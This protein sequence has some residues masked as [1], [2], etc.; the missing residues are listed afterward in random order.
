MTLKSTRKVL[1]HSL[2]RSIVGSHRSLIRLL[3][4]ARFARALRY[5]PLRSAMLAHSLTPELMRKRIWSTERM[6]RFHTVST[7]CAN[8]TEGSLA[9]FLVCTLIGSLVPSHYSL[10][11]SILL[12]LFARTTRWLAVS[13]ALVSELVQKGIAQF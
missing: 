12:A 9:F 10:F 2:L 11:C 1:G 13:A 3:R 6:R 4:T 8:T 5:A 7:H